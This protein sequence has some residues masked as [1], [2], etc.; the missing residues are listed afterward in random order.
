[1]QIWPSWVVRSMEAEQT[2]SARHFGDADDLDGRCC[3]TE[4]DEKRW[5]DLGRELQ[6]TLGHDRERGS[7]RGDAIAP[8]MANRRVTDRDLGLHVRSR[9]AARL[10]LRRR[11]AGETCPD[12]RCRRPPRTP[13][14]LQTLPVGPPSTSSFGTRTPVT[15]TESEACPF[16]LHH[17]NRRR[18]AAAGRRRM[19][20]WR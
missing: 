15:S 12:F 5:P 6:L 19:R 3:P 18:P 8:T 20:R 7:A 14:D 17:R 13:G 9:S 1:M 2:G 11:Q 10:T 16:G 4:T